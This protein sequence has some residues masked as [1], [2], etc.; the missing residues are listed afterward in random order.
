M[1]RG[2]GSLLL[3]VTLLAGCSQVDAVG[4]S[5]HVVNIGYQK[6]STLSLLKARGTLEKRLSENGIQV[7]WYEFQAGPPLLEALNAEAIDI[8]HTGDS[9]P[10]FA[11]SAGVPLAYIGASA[12]SPNSFAIVVLDDTDIRAVADLKGKRVGFV[13]GSS[14]HTLVLRALEREQLTLAD[15]EPVYLAPSDARAALESRSIDAWS[16]WDPFLSVAEE[17]G[18]V[19]ILVN[20]DGIVAGREFHLT[21]R[22]FL[23]RNRELAVAVLQ[24]LRLVKEWAQANPDEVARLYQEQTNLPLAALRRAEERRGR[25]GTERASEVLIAEQQQLADD[26]FKLQLIPHEV[27]V[28]EAVMLLPEAWK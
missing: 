11:Q 8:G 10:I 4:T 1:V 9:P 2:F 3:A 22:S 6:W 26:Y 27:K 18:N 7:R 12:P 20:G 15:I 28:H 5:Q 19:R 24:E 21:S 16:I 14:A 17:A 13:K 23:D 25:Y